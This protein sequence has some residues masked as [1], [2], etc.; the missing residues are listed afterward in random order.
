MFYRNFEL[1][2]LDKIQAVKELPVLYVKHG[3]ISL[4]LFDVSEIDFML[5]SLSA[6]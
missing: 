5:E 2:E 6:R 1:S 3:L 4:P